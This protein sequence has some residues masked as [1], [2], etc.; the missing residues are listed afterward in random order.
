MNKKTISLLFCVLLILTILIGCTAKNPTLSLTF[1][2][3]GDVCTYKGPDKF[4]YG[5]FTLNLVQGKNPAGTIGY[6]IVTLDEGKTVDDL[7]A[8]NSTDTPPF[9]TVL[10]YGGPY[11]QDSNF[12]FDLSKMAAYVQGKPLYLACFSQA[13]GG[14]IKA[15]GNFGPID[16][17]Q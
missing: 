1:N 14:E 9:A 13:K 6:A 10:T 4:Q 16:I 12:D 5:T 7:K 8:W 11:S 3:A 17:K 2:D 15:V